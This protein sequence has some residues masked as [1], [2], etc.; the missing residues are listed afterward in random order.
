MKKL[1]PTQE[2]IDI[3]DE[4]LSC[5]GCRDKCIMLVFGTKRAIKYGKRAEKI[6]RKFWK[7]SKELYPELSTGGWQYLT[8]EEVYEEITDKRSN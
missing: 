7:L 6:R 4:Y 5:I 8:L 3:N 1:K 2:L